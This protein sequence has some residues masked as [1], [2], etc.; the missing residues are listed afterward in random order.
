MFVKGKPWRSLFIDWLILT[1]AARSKQKIVPLSL[2][3][4]NVRQGR[5]NMGFAGHTSTHDFS[6]SFAGEV[7]NKLDVAYIVGLEAAA[8]PP[9]PADIWKA[10][11]SK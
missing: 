6:D 3:H 10:A 8:C 7:F 4:G 1:P 11:R 9:M 2:L 5:K